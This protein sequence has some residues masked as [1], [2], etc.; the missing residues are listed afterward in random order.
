MLLK[1]IYINNTHIFSLFSHSLYFGPT[2]PG[3]HFQWPAVTVGHKR[4][5]PGVVG[6]TGT[7]IELET[8]TEPTSEK[9][10]APRVFYVHNFLSAEETDELIRFST[11]DENPYKMRPSTG[12]TH[13]VSYFYLIY[14]H[15]RCIQIPRSMNPSRM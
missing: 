8:L 11:A 15:V 6:G 3:T 10:S 5:V 7:Q 9:N 14:E 13:K 2:R 12:G 1:S 4:L